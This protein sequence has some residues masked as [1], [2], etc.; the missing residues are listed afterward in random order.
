MKNKDLIELLQR[1]DPN[2]EVVTSSYDAIAGI[3]T[4]Y[5][6]V[7]IKHVDVVLYNDGRFDYYREPHEDENSIE[8]IEIV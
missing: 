7:G 2:A 8:V 3:T 4:R 1:H 6:T 5:P